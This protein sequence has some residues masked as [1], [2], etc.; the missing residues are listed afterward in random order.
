MF[1]PRKV[2]HAFLNYCGCTNECL[3][4]IPPRVNNHLLGSFPDKNDDIID[5][6]YYTT[7]EMDHRG[8]V[9]NAL[10]LLVRVSTL[11]VLLYPCSMIEA[12]LG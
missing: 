10:M 12:S 9:F 1:W 11:D 4:E 7:D 5:V 3:I 2:Q 6:D 8:H